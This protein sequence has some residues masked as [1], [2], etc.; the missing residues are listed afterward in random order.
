MSALSV[1]KK[2]T[3]TDRNDYSVRVMRR[4]LS[5][6]DR[7]PI[8]LHVRLV[9]AIDGVKRHMRSGV[10]TTHT[11]GPVLGYEAALRTGAYDHCI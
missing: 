3:I 1:G 2:V 6:R 4:S 5:E 9:Q 7:R 10:A 11:I 8:N